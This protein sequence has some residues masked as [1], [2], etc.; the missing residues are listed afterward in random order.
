M[1]G[2]AIQRQPQMVLDAVH[3]GKLS[4]ETLD[5]RVKAVLELLV[6]AGKFENPEAP[7]PEQAIDL[8]EHRSLIRKAG[9]EGIVLLKNTNDIL[10]LKAEGLK[11]IALLG[12]SQRCLAHGGGSAAV[13]AHHKFTPWDAFKLALDGKVEMKYAEGQLYIVS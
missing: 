7:P 3:S 5:E 1:P 4:I 11:S 10:P 6:K 8:P 2:P 12:L 9:A 13:N